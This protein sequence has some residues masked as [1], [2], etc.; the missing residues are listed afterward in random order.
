VILT[1]NSGP[2]VAFADINGPD[3]QKAME[4][5]KLL[6]T[7]PNY[8]ALSITVDV[9]DPSSVERMVTDVA[10][11]F[12]RIDY[13]VHSAGVRSLLSFRVS[14]LKPFSLFV[15][16]TDILWFPKG[17][18]ARSAKR[19][20]CL[21][22]G[23]PEILRRQRQGHALVCPSSQSAD[24]QAGPPDATFPLKSAWPRLRPGS[25]NKSWL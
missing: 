20:K 19:L 14:D 18:G 7:N 8:Q 23:V 10:N 17:G 21:P 9:S 1:P 24:A 6:A 22:I 12:G 3:A 15:S 16:L 5:S 13:S 25:H 2:T 4:D 11:K